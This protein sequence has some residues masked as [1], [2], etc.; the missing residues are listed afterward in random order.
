[1]RN[2]T[3][4]IDPRYDLGS[5]SDDEVVS[6]LGELLASERQTTA[7][8]LC[9][10]AEVDA[11]KLFL[12]H[13]CNSMFVYATEIL[14]LSE[15]AAYRRIQAARV[16][17]RHPEV[18]DDVAAGRL[19]V[20]GLCVLSPHVDG[21]GGKQLLDAARGRSVRQIRELCAGAC[22]EPRVPD[23]ITPIGDGRFVFRFTAGAAVREKL[24]KAQAL[25][26]H[27]VPDFA[28]AEVFERALDALI[29]KTRKQRFA[30]T[31]S[32]RAP[33]PSGKRTRHIPAEVRRE[34]ESRD[35]GQC[36]FVGVGGRRCGARAFAQF[37]HEDPYGRGGEHDLSNVRLLCAHHNALLA[38]EEYGEE[39]LAKAR[40]LASERVEARPPV[41][42]DESSEKLAS[43][44]ARDQP[45]STRG[46]HADV[47]KGLVRLGFRTAEAQRAVADAAVTLDPNVPIEELAYAALRKSGERLRATRPWN[48]LE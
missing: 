3:T 15:G 30:E 6:Q 47:V 35:G 13:G 36:T 33:R 18:F 16:A 44:P 24:E 25:L 14:G 37:H 29:E 10:M 27:S 2:H 23:A 22:P 7:D 31:D 26:S 1:M 17:R 11:R 41:L 46:Q 5:T 32:P 42:A 40:G 39:H 48:R 4:A 45:G 9:R 28:M 38:E 20:A 21:V 8:V 34:V 43:E 19:T 12:H